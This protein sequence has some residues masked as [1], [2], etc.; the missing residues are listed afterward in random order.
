M[1]RE[2]LEWLAWLIGQQTIA[3]GSP[4]ARDQCSRAFAA[5]DEIGAALAKEDDLVEQV[6]ANG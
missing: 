6:A 5:L 4:D 2:T 1:T 3:L